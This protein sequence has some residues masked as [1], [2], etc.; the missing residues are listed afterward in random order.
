MG[1]FANLLVQLT[2]PAFILAIVAMFIKMGA[3]R[4]GDMA[5]FVRWTWISFF[6]CSFV[7]ALELVQF[8]MI[9]SAFSILL[10][11]LWGWF[12]WR[13]FQVLRQIQR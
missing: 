7:A 13:D 6:A 2:F 10:A 5:G 12:A 8:I 11:A 3:Q 9:Q 4:K 1:G